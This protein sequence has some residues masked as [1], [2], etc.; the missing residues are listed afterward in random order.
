LFGSDPPC[1]VPSTDRPPA[2][3]ALVCG[4][5]SH[6]YPRACRVHCRE[7]HELRRHEADHKFVCQW[8]GTWTIDGA[9]PDCYCAY[10]ARSLLRTYLH[11]YMFTVLL[12]SDADKDYY[13]ACN[14]SSTWISELAES[15]KFTSNSSRDK[16]FPRCLFAAFLYFN[17]NS[18]ICYV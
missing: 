2:N 10:Y 12:H 17:R 6:Y 15:I 3:G 16:S 13:C 11:T 9:W 8:D 1:P 5:L 18:D 14:Y 4:S 7:G